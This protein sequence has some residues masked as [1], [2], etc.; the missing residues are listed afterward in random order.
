METE[1]KYYT[2][3]FMVRI[4]C[5]I[6][7]I[8]QGYDKIFVVKLEGVR[9]TFYSETDKRNIPR[10]FVNFLAAYT[11]Y[12][13]LLAGIFLLLG[14]FK[15]YALIGLGIDL[16][17]VGA[18]FSYMQAMWDMKYV[19]PRLVLV[20]LLLVLPNSWEFLSLDKLIQ[21]YLIK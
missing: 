12:V 5:A 20:A 18:S 3:E 4:F 17:L 19:F 15:T 1:I 7:F 14:L 8:F 10:F 2:L 11:S 13:E 9:Q 21:T 6:L 16:I